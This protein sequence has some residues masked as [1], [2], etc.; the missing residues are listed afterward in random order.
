M[1]YKVN[2]GPAQDEHYGINLARMIGFPEQFIDVAED[3][4]SALERQIEEK[5]RTSQSRQLALRRKLILN[6]FESL[7]QLRNS[8]MDDA[9]LGSYLNQLQGEFVLRMDGIAQNG[10]ATYEDGDESVAE[11]IDAM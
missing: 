5:K 2:S 7:V 9:A 3:V 11:E 6:L 4:S 1:L 10:Q 8:D